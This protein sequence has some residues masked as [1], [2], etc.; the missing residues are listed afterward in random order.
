M[1]N[2]EKAGNWRREIMRGMD[3]NVDGNGL[4]RDDVEC[5]HGRNVV[6]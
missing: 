6:G 3:G 2:A 4:E 5:D 1:L